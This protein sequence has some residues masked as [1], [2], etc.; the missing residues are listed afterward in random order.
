M[1]MGYGDF[2]GLKWIPVSNAGLKIMVMGYDKFHWVQM[3][4]GRLHWV[5]KYANGL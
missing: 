5:K 3:S 4:L 1:L 2:S